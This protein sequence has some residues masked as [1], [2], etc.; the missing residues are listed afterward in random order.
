MIGSFV[1]S[2]KRALFLEYCFCPVHTTCKCQ[3]DS[4]NWLAL[5][6][7]YDPTLSSAAWSSQYIVGT[8]LSQILCYIYIYIYIYYWERERECEQETE[9]DRARERQ[10]ETERESFTVCCFLKCANWFYVASVRNNA[11]WTLYINLCYC[12]TCWLLS[13][14]AST[15]VPVNILLTRTS[16]RSA[17]WK[18]ADRVD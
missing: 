9:R 18:S 12:Y 15:C 6:T 3:H 2:F 7:A 5:Q 10:R 17:G 4:D 11:L 13:S 8:L 1:W 14:I 16:S